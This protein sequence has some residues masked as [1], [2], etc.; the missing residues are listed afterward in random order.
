MQ[1]DLLH[2]LAFHVPA[3]VRRRARGCRLGSGFYPCGPSVGPHPTIKLVMILVCRI[4]RDKQSQAP[5][6]VYPCQSTSRA[7]L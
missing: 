1:G 3:H 7:T 5:S 6:S 2:A 4:G